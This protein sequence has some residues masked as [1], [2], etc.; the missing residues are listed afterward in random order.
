[1]KRARVA[2]ILAAGAAVRGTCRTSSRATGRRRG[3]RLD[4]ASARRSSTVADDL[5]AGDERQRGAVELAVDDVQVGAA[6]A[7]GVH[8][9][10]HVAAGRRLEVRALGVPQSLAGL[11][12]AP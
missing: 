1:M 5:V 11:R 7:A 3:R 2:Q 10:E 8:V 9:E 4:A 12:G 6:D